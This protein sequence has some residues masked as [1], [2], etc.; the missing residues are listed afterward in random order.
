MDL[1]KRLVRKLV[2]K[3][4]VVFAEECVRSVR[5]VVWQVYYR[6]PGKKLRIIAVTGTNGKTTTVSYINSMLKT[7]GLKTAAYTTA[8]Y[9]VDGVL[10]TNK[11]HMTVHSQKTVQRFFAQA[12]KAHVDF[13]VLEITSNALDQKRVA[14]IKVEVAVVTNLTQD[15]L[16][17]HKTMENYAAAKARLLSK[18]YSPRYCVLN[19]DDAWYDFFKTRAEGEVITYGKE[20]TAQLNIHDIELSSDGSRALVGSN[21]LKTRL[22]GTFNIYN[23]TAALGVARALSI[24]VQTALTGINQ[25]QAVPGRM[26][27]IDAGQE[28]SVLVDFAVTPDALKQVLSSLQDVSTGNVR[29]VFGATGDRDKAKRPLMGMV[30]AQYADHIYLTDDETYTED[31]DTIRNAVYEG[32]KSAQGENKTTVIADRL[33][34]IK[35]AFHDA[36]KGDVVLL[37]GI[38]SEDYRNMNGKKQPWDEREIAKEYL[39]K[40]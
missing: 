15:H 10:E 29:V 2:P 22:V 25:L 40:L 31:P 21:V 12:R 13:V 17:Y 11:T 26:E 1:G 32:I 8:Y 37:A 30:A 34:A 39:Q 6:F 20:A 36:K 38:G 3:R 24:D 4:G 19:T 27:P 33:E 9:E 14:G 16:D 35:T 5:A 7:A 28:F 18:E 23:A